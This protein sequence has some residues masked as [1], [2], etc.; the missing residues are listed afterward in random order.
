MKN[1]RRRKPLLQLKGKDRFEGFRD[2][3]DD[4]DWVPEPPTY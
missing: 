3:T 4:D 1:K 2:Y